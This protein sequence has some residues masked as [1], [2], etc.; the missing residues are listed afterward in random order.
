MKSFN[1]N[2]QTLDNKTGQIIKQ[3]IQTIICNHERFK[4]CYN[5]IQHHSAAGRRSQEFSFMFSFRLGGVHYKVWQ[6][7]EISCKN[8]YF[9]TLVKLD[10]EKKTIRA[11]KKLVE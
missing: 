9:K 10:G 5:W 2:I 4:G 3:Q 7:L 11:L 6:S 8:F 1:R